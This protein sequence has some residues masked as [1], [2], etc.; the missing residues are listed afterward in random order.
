MKSSVIQTSILL[1]LI[2][3]S[4]EL[5]VQTSHKLL[6]TSNLRNWG[7]SHKLLQH[8]VAVL[9]GMISLSLISYKAVVSKIAVKPDFSKVS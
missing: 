2:A 1:L 9:I 7:N 5:K 4:K 6:N 3:L 8:Q